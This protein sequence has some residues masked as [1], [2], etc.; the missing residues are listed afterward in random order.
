MEELDL[1]LSAC[2]YMPLPAGKRICPGQQMALSECS[3]ASA[4][5]VQ[6]SPSIENRD[7]EDKF[8]EQAQNDNAEPQ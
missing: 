3:Y 7:P 1:K 6:A 2:E 4:R 5:Y 8:V